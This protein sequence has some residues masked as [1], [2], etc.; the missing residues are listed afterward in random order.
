MEAK[1]KIFPCKIKIDDIEVTS[2]D[3]CALFRFKHTHLMFNAALAIISGKGGKI[4]AR[5]PI[6]QKTELTLNQ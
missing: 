5:K 6:E 4:G 1:T 3:L 2:E